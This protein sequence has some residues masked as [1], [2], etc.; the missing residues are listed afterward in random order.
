MLI[1]VA[2]LSYAIAAVVFLL[3]S[4][5][6]M[7]TWRGRLHWVSLALA[8]LL[9]AAWAAT[10]ALH[11]YLE[12][13]L[14][15][16]AQCLEFAKSA[17]W[18]V[19]LLIL[20]DPPQQIRLA[21][22]VNAKPYVLIIS[23]F[24]LLQLAAT[25][26]SNTALLHFS[27]GF[28]YLISAGGRVAMA[29]I[30][31]LLVEQFFRNMSDK[32][33]WGI[34]F[35]CLGIGGLFVY[36]FYLYSDA[37]LFRKINVEIWAARGIVDAL[38]VPLLAIAVARNP[39]WSQGIL[40]SRRILFHSVTL[41]GAAFYLL[42]M[43]AAGYYLRFFGGNWGF[44]M[45][46]AFLFGAVILL[47]ILLFSGSVRSWLK[48]FI[49]KHFYNYNYD[50]REEWIRFTRT[51]STQGPDLGERAIRALA[52]LV[53]SPA[54]ALYISR[55]SGNCEPSSHWNMRLNGSVE[56]INSG[57]CRLLEEKQWVIDLQD[58]DI[59]SDTY[60][61]VAV[62]AWLSAYERAWLVLPLILHGKLF[63]FVILAQARSKIKLNWE[64]LDLLKI[65]GSQAASY[66]AQ[67]DS[68][69]ALM[70]ARQFESFNRMSTF[71]VHDLKNL[72]AQLSLLLSNAEKHK[73]NPEFQK[74]MLDTIDHSVQ[75]MKVLLQK[76]SRGASVDDRK[77][78]LLD[79]L[80]RRAV[81]SKSPYEPKPVLEIL[82]SAVR[83]EA[84]W[85][86]L[87]RVIGHLVQNAIEATPKDGEVRVRLTIQGNFAVVE[88]KDTGVGMSKEFILDK[89]FSPFV[90]TK[91]AGMGIGV[92]E[93]KEYV[94]E[95]GGK[96]EVSSTPSL[97]TTFKIILSIH[98]SEEQVA[99][100]AV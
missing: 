29:V 48:V 59:H 40:V 87:E 55:E 79:Q 17:G 7:T 27:N 56:P 3:L 5:L 37:M 33:R 36:D 26:Y 14:T 57:F 94:Q 95:L 62:P 16:F 96:L 69:N 13:P 60:E 99:L 25:V 30:G 43:A 64:V 80:L 8:C 74:D 90:S 11:A 31:M 32:G 49:S 82:E 81:E 85:E 84:N 22:I 53:E 35:A 23:A 52:E 42:A 71:M 6:L 45:Q 12:I 38:T 88:I 47:V 65:A 20:L 67:Q 41:F 50:Y 78:V 100:R 44:V 73:N 97:G 61:G 2:F 83:V 28:I 75:K 63:G 21:S 51:L 68:S 46:V 1:N 91:V 15:L 89:L 19:F 4:I 24:L 93:T 72:V 58:F 98:G 70:V 39:K 34:K 66:L 76:L 86:R 10:L 54:A 77:I 92:F 18:I 9:T